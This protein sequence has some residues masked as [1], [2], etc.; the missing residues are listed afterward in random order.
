LPQLHAPSAQPQVAHVQLALP[1][2]G[3]MMIVVWGVSVLSVWK[4]CVWIVALLC[5]AVLVACLPSKRGSDFSLSTPPGTL[6][7]PG[8]WPKTAMGRVCARR[9]SASDHQV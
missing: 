1:Q 7:P 4:V 2:P 3:M 8:T 5:I 6:P 9:G